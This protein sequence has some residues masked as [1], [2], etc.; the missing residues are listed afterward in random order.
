MTKK[1]D[2]RP[3]A[4]ELY[5]LPV[6][7]RVPLKFGPETLTHVTC[8]RV[9]M[10]VSDTD[11][12]TAEGWAETPLSVQWV[13]PGELSYEVRH[14]ALKEFCLALT[15]AWAK[16]EGVGHPMEIAHAFQEQVLLRLLRDF[17]Q[18]RSEGPMPYLAALVCCS[19]FDIALHDA[20]G[21]LH[22]VD[23]YETYNAE[24]MNV[25]LSAFLLPAEGTDVS[26]D[27]LYPA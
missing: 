21:Q 23:V 8:A 26:F 19:A 16:W 20:Y 14:E 27:G 18:D 15:D 10:T 6:E 5:F 1:T 3:I 22:G 2:I 12:N 4:A 11:G 24:Y 25:D 7:T 17:S 13:W 9:K